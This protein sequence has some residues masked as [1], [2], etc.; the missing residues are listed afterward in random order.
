MTVMITGDNDKFV[1]HAKNGWNITKTPLLM[2][3]H[4][5]G[6]DVAK[7]F[8]TDFSLWVKPYLWSGKGRNTGNKR[9]KGPQ[10]IIIIMVA[11]INC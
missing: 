3:H 11:G 10:I 6:T 2:V 9:H 5:E 8:S 1:F 7:V 4:D